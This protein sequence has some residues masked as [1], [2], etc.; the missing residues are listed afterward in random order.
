MRKT[1][2]RSLT[3]KGYSQYKIAK[4]LKIRKSKVVLAQKQ[5]KIGVRRPSLFWSDVKSYQR[6]H[7]ESWKVAVKDTKDQ[8]YW[9]RK[10]AARQGKQYKSYSDFWKEWKEKWRLTSQEE[11]DKHG[12]EATYGEEGEFVGGTPH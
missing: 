1:T 10:R 7:E 3:A 9:A 8:P 4:I 2:V 6:V 5:L 12:Y 11:R